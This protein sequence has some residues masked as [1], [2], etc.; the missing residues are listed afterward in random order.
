MIK[1]SNKNRNTRDAQVAAAM[2]GREKPL[3]H[4]AASNEDSPREAG[5]DAENLLRP[6]SPWQESHVAWLRL[7]PDKKAT[8]SISSSAIGVIVVRCHTFV[9]TITSHAAVAEDFRSV[10]LCWESSVFRAQ[11]V[12]P[13]NHIIILYSIK[14][15][16]SNFTART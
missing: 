12:A 14:S 15:H 16:T 8:S 2:M 6:H 9:G 1:A 13:A 5:P 3:G 4:K 7:S 10:C 11:T